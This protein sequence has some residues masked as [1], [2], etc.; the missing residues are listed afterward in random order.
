MARDP[1][2]SIPTR[3]SLLGRLKDWQDQQSWQEFFDTYWR[4]IYG[5]AARAGLSDAEAQEVV[6]ETWISV[7]KQMPDFTYDPQ[8]GSFR[9]WLLAI[10]RRRIVDQ[11][12]RM[13]RNP[14]QVSGE[15]PSATGTA[16]IERV[17]APESLD[18][19]RIWEEEWRQG[20]FQK[21]LDRVR[22]EVDPK[23]FQIFDCYVLKGWPVEEVVRLLKVSSSQVYV[24]KHRI[25]ALLKARIETLDKTFR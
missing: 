20:L 18:L 24:V 21:A 9:S 6:Q 3:Q 16:P 19:D 15:P 8:I 5:V 11:I 22:A 17:P 14:A 12:R 13:A 7:A 23:H 25:A 10:T 2:D 1:D 4:L